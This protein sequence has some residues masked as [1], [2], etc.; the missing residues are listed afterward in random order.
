MP[1]PYL[2]AILDAFSVMDISMLHL[3]LKDEYS[4]QDTTKEIFL[5][6][7][8]VI[9]TK[10]QR[11]GDTHLFCH[12][13]RC[14]SDECT[15]CGLGGYRFVSN[16]SQTYIDL[17]FAVDGED[18]KDIFDCSDFKTEQPC[19]EIQN[20]L[21]IWI[22]RDEKESF[23]KDTVYWSKVNDAEKA[24]QELY[25]PGRLPVS[26]EE[27]GYWLDKHWFTFQR[28]GPY[29]IFEGQMRWTPFAELYDLLYQ[30]REFLKSLKIDLNRA[31]EAIDNLHDEAA[32]VK[33]LMEYE[34]FYEKIPY[35]IKYG[36]S[37]I[38]AE[39][40]RVS[41]TD[42]VNEPMV[43]LLNKLII[44]FDDKYFDMVLKYSIYNQEER[45]EIEE[46]NDYK[47]T[48]FLNS[49]KFH[50]RKREE[51]KEMGIDIPLNLQANEGF[52]AGESRTVS[53]D[54][55]PF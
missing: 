5:Q 48:R 14:K 7:I 6:K 19:S 31:V 4:Y 26:I 45:N 35:D 1:S 46:S 32:L 15:N 36:C 54:T 28:T 53:G 8:A 44:Q 12:K 18:V 52:S 17:L 42:L 40:E 24:Y 22:N 13:G 25:K 11:L 38:D 16:H 33:W 39:K 34:E 41:I 9:F 37:Y 50:I 23:V 20:S 3:L 30:L 21:S 55:P 27:A 10:L 43:Q 47:E 2:Q 51:A 49:L 29:D